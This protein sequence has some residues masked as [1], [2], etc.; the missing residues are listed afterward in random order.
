MLMKQARCLFL[1]KQSNGGGT[2]DPAV[3]RVPSAF[4]RVD[5]CLYVIT[6][7]TE[8][9]TRYSE[10]LQSSKALVRALSDIS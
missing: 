6:V 3:C 7:N 10:V 2:C 4:L 1:H 5:Q 8:N 9:A